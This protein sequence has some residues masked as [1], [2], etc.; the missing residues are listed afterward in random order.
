MTKRQEIAMAR[1]II[2]LMHEHNEEIFKSE[3]LDVDSRDLL[4][5]DVAHMEDLRDQEQ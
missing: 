4:Y 5:A 2:F 1:L 3:N